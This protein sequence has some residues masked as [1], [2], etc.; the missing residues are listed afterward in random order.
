MKVAV[1]YHSK[2]G[3]TQKVAEIIG[4]GLKEVENIE[5][6]LMRID[7]IDYEFVKESKAVIFGTSTYYANISWQIKKWFDE[8][9]GCNLEGKIGAVF[10]TEDYLGGGADTALITLIGHMMVKGMLLY[11]GGSALGQPY[12]HMGIV[13]IK[14]GDENQKE[15]AKIFGERIGKKVSELF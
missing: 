13:T 5:V 8:S 3:N 10:A 6:K 2:S 14:D 7:E 4:E 1:I 12:I 11:S 9:W 15:R